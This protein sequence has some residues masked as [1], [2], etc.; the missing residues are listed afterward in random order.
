MNSKIHGNRRESRDIIRNVSFYE[1]RGSSKVKGL[2]AEDCQM[3][4]MRR[5]Q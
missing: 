5:R 2:D 4:A 3:W 1:S